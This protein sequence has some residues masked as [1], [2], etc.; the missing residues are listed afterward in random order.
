MCQ[1]LS[2]HVVQYITFVKSIMKIMLTETV[3]WNKFYVK[4][5]PQDNDDD[6]TLA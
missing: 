1:Q 5:E 3:D 6:K 2:L 4:R